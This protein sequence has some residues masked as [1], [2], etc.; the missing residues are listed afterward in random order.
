MGQFLNSFIRG[1]GSTLGRAAA[2][3]A[4]SAGGRSSVTP[5]G[6][7]IFLLFLLISFF[8]ILK[9]ASSYEKSNPNK[10]ITFNVKTEDREVIIC[11]FETVEGKNKGIASMD[12]FKREENG[13]L[14][15]IPD[16]LLSASQNILLK[17]SE[18]II[19]KS[20][21]YEDQIVKVGDKDTINVILHKIK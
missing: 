7:L 15:I 11:S 17:E 19:I 13:K 6:I 1:F 20:E 18:L 8:G 2:R 12:L 10:W 16:S 3:N 9:L 4:M 14:N 5:K 21:G